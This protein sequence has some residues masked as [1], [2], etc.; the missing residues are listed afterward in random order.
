MSGS[1]PGGGGGQ[2][3]LLV[4]VQGQGTERTLTLSGTLDYQT[5]EQLRTVVS[6]Q[7]SAGVTILRLNLGQ[8][9][10][11]DMGGIHLLL[12][13]LEELPQG[14]RLELIRPSTPVRRLLRLSGIAANKRVRVTDS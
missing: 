3:T 12:D 5:A 1:K 14:G 10:I 6:E 9:V 2:D 7:L 8:L 4:A 11:M 13:L